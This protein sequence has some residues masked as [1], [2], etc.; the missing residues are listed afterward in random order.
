MF[1]LSDDSLATILLCSR[2]VLPKRPGQDNGPQPL[3]ANEWADISATL[4]RID[5]RPSHLL[6]WS[7]TD[8]IDLLQLTPDHADRIA[9]LL[10]R[11]GPA[12]IELERLNAQG[13]WAVTPSDADYPRR[14][15]QTIGRKSPP[16]LF[17][18]GSHLTD[19]QLSVAIVGARDVDEIGSHFAAVLAERCA[20]ECL[21]VV[22][23]GARGV[24][25]LAML[26]ALESNG[27]VV[28]VLADSLERATRD[29]RY[30]PSI[31]EGR[32]TLLTPYHPSAGFD[33]GSAMGRNHII[34]RLS[35]YAVVVASSTERGGTRSGAL[36][37]L[38]HRW[39]P[40]LVRSG[41]DAPDGNKDL[42]RRGGRP[43]TDAQLAAP[44][45]FIDVLQGATTVAHQP[46]VLV[47]PGLFDQATSNEQSSHALVKDSASSRESRPELD[48]PGAETTTSGQL[49]ILELAW[50]TL[51]TILQSPVSEKQIAE[52]LRLELSQ[53]RAW[54]K[55]LVDDGR[56]EK[57]DRPVR[58]RA[59]TQP[60]TARLPGLEG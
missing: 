27:C 56:I 16:V 18:S 7:A 21:T 47:T 41:T 22:S 9:T 26:A 32:L 40:L 20:S 10:T 46:D 45:S 29:R 53:V 38:K 55:R 51:R 33:P 42:I 60:L 54:L 44:G 2:L 48:P 25:Q 28:G 34:Y 50:P 49:D 58:Y 6:G 8:L 23:G 1:R 17:G 30:R 35:N 19:E 52:T 3:S 4:A 12:A 37:N 57:K 14:L 36:E 59:T 31:L 5:R 39:T 11:A 24:D 43:L 13:I 15:A